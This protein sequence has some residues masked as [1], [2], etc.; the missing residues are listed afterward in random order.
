MKNKSKFCFV[1]SRI[2]VA[3]WLLEI[4]KSISFF[5][6]MFKTIEYEPLMRL[7]FPTDQMKMVLRSTLRRFGRYVSSCSYSANSV[8]FDSLRRDFSTVVLLSIRSLFSTWPS[9]S[10]H[11]ESDRFFPPGFMPQ[12]IF[13][14][15]HHE[16]MNERSIQFGFWC[17]SL[18]VIYNSLLILSLLLP[19]PLSPCA[20]RVMAVVRQMG[21]RWFMGRYYKAMVHPG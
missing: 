3:S 18:T 13:S 14:S 20:V 21:R 8:S 19:P 5:S 2:S 12:S 4:M 9:R 6:L 10:S 7:V 11:S 15:G 16:C 1:I 17:Y